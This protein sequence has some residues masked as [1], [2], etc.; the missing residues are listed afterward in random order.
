[1]NAVRLTLLAGLMLL[2][3]CTNTTKNV[4]VS[5]SPAEPGAA[6]YSDDAFH[7]LV[8]KY[9][10]E[11]GEKVD[12]ARWKDSPEDMAALDQHIAAIG[13][14]SPVST[15]QQFPTPSDR[16]SYWINTYNALVLRAVLELWP[17]DSVRDVKVSLTSRVVPGKG[18]FY[19]RK[20]IVGGQETSLYR[21][22]K[23]VL[24]SQK[25]PRLHFALNCA[26]DSCPV[27]R[28]WEWTDEQLDQASREFVSR[29][30]NVS[31][32]DN[33]LQVSRIFKWYRK[34][35]PKNL[36]VYLQQYADDDLRQQL[37]RADD[38]NFRVRYGE[39]D[40]SLNASETLRGA[41]EYDH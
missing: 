5:E 14:L 33:A 32:E 7:D 29:P 30:E 21:L 15:P 38:G 35:F 3:A 26:S 37:I 36:A 19:D 23:D 31:V 39:Y 10:V 20:V 24:A 11:D 41:D 16:R 18:F 34:D 25:D 4:T 6:M 1:M 40:W 9:A 17:L 28:P 13:R 12:Y 22:E 8:R 2:S 27:L